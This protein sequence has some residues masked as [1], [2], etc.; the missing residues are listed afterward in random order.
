MSDAADAAKKRN[1]KKRDRKGKEP[2]TLEVGSTLPAFSGTTPFGVVLRSR[3]EVGPEGTARAIVVVF[4][5]LGEDAST[6]VL[7]ETRKLDVEWSSQGVTVVLV[8]VGNDA[9]AVEARALEAA[10]GWPV[11]A[12]P[13]GEIARAFAV[14]DLPRAFVGDASGM[15]RAVHEG[16]DTD[17]HA[18]IRRSLADVL[19]VEMPWGESGRRS[20]L[21]SFDA[22]YRFGRPP[23]DAGAA[24]RWQPLA[25][26]MGEVANVFISM[27]SARTYEEFEKKVRAA[28]FEI[29]NAG[30]ATGAKMLERYEPVARFDRRGQPTY[31]G[32]FF[33]RRDRG[34]AQ[35]DDLRGKTVA[36]VS[37]RSTSGGLYPAASLIQRGLRLEDD[38]RLLWVK[39]H[40]NVAE[41]VRDGKADAGACYDDCRDLAWKSAKDRDAATVV[42]GKTAEIPNEMVFL[43]RDLPREKKA[44]LR[45]ALLSIGAKELVIRQLSRSE[46]PITG[47]SPADPSELARVREA[48]EGVAEAIDEAKRKAAKREAEGR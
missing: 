44:R 13:E 47:V 39:T 5:D 14:S 1:R 33:A 11:L 4:A 6:R 34:I 18:Q 40:K 42:V 28:E 9:S 31:H 24:T 2:P 17:L 27:A 37:E 32:I 46:E 8:G 15:L 22:K 16:A 20:T 38:V 48:L 41:A 29:V 35:L 10:A 21:L 36:M 30:P 3:E 45:A 7:N 43:R 19:G 23:S 26:Y 25:K 12:D